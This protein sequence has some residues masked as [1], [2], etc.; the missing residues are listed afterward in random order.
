MIEVDRIMVNEL[1]VPVELMM[2]HAGHSLAKL[3]VA[4]SK[5]EN[6]EFCIIAGSGNNGGGGLVAARR[7][8]NWN[9]DVRVIIPKGFSSLR[10]GPMAQLIRLQSMGVDA[11]DNMPH[12]FPENDTILDAFI[13]YGYRKRDDAIASLVFDSI[14]SHKRVLSLDAPS[15]LDVTTG[16]S[17]SGVHP[18]ATMTLAFVKIGLLKASPQEVGELYVCDIGVPAE[19][20][21]NRLGIDWSEPFDANA[22][23]SL[24]DAFAADPLNKVRLSYSDN[25]QCWN[26]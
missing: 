9:Y 7:M 16:V 10:E 11:E 12:S 24:S 22:I 13:G 3:A 23:D 20:Y 5:R 21:L 8:V 25:Y 15:G 17:Y 18:I 6:P 26:V 1:K 14:R 4:L 2:E 19:I